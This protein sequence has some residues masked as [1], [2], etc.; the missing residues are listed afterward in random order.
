M[1]TT[2][3][4]RAT[5]ARVWPM[6]VTFCDVRERGGADLFNRR[7]PQVQWQNGHG[8]QQALPPTR[9]AANA[10][11]VI[12]VNATV[13]N[14]VSL[15]LMSELLSNERSLGQHAPLCRLNTSSTSRA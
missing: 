5:L 6:V 10:A 7:R 1:P 11:V 9:E 15:R 8:G 3:R 12:R 13:A 2:R 4:M 14:A